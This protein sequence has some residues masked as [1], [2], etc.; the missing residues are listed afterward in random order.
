MVELRLF[1]LGNL[2]LKVFW[3][4]PCLV[5]V[6]SRYWFTS[7][8]ALSRGT[9]T[10]DTVQW[11]GQIESSIL[12]SQWNL[13][14][15]GTVCWLI[16]SARQGIKADGKLDKHLGFIFRSDFAIP[17]RELDEVDR[18][19]GIRPSWRRSLLWHL[20]NFVRVCLRT[21]LLWSMSWS[22]HPMITGICKDI[23]S[24]PTQEFA[25][26]LTYVSWPRL[27]VKTYLSDNYW[28]F[29]GSWGQTT[30]VWRGA[31]LQK[32]PQHQTVNIPVWTADVNLSQ[33]ISGYL[34]WLF[35][36]VFHRLELRSARCG[37]PFF[38]HI[39]VATIKKQQCSQLSQLTGEGFQND[40]CFDWNLVKGRSDQANE[41]RQA[42]GAPMKS[43]ILW[44]LV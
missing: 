38:G 19:E 30:G 12:G 9:L 39:L 31:R 5:T 8:R 18:P 14:W 24:L 27:F 4:C 1:F 25:A 37:N 41:H 36:S 21:L 40:G 22:H 3:V 2:A 16:C 26:Y 34:R 44:R 15:L 33:S 7:W 43:D 35:Q 32:W 29:F 42:D 11:M 10:E 17:L 23:L 6:T 13:R 20:K 28:V